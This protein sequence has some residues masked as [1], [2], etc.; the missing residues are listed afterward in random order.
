[1]KETRS[2]EQ[3]T[4]N[5]LGGSGSEWT[6]CGRIL[7]GKTVETTQVVQAMSNFAGL[8]TYSPK[9]PEAKELR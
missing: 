4:Q 7:Q 2:L 6:A 1:M 3:R 9:H 5:I 8:K